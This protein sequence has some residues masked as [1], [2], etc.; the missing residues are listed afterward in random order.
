[1]TANLSS[2][3]KAD[4]LLSFNLLF[5]KRKYEKEGSDKEGA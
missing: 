5:I 2:S 1:M 4:L 3:L